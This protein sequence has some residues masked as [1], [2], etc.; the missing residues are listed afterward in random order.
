MDTPGQPPSPREPDGRYAAGNPGGP[1]RPKGNKMSAHQRAAQEAVSP[2]HIQALMRVAL[3]QG[4]Q[5]NLQATRLVLER[6]CGRAPEG[7]ADAE[8]LDIMLPNLRTAANCTAAIDKIIA[9]ISA[10]TVDLAS[11]K[12]L[13]DAVQSRMKGIEL[14]EHEARL[15][16]LEEATSTVELPGNARR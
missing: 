12:V 8:P 1:G 15:L 16:E 11:A 3:K 5:G 10:G 14:N 6:T 2:D 7:R 4:L 13:L 9:A